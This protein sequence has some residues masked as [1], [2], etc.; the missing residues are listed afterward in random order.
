MDFKED[1]FL[2]IPGN[3]TDPG[4]KQVF[5][6]IVA[7]N[8]TLKEYMQT[9][10][11]KTFTLDYLKTYTLEIREIKK[12][13]DLYFICS[14]NSIYYSY[15]ES[16]RL[17]LFN[18]IENPINDFIFPTSK[19]EPKIKIK[20]KYINI[21]DFKGKYLYKNN[22]KNKFE[23]RKI[24]TDYISKNSIEL[25]V[26]YQIHTIKELLTISFIEI[27]KNN[28]TINKCQNCGKYF[29]P[30]S[31]SDEKYCNNPSPQNP[32]KTCKEY[33]AKKKYRDEIK[34]HPIKYEHNKTSQ[35]YRMRINRTKNNQEKEKYEKKFN[36]Y[37]EN[38]EKKKKQYNSGKLKEND[39]V[40]WIIKQKE[41]VKNGS[42]RTNK[43]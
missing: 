33:G 18:V 12:L 22:T 8:S 26:T 13:I 39:F 4:I 38:F 29:I 17:F 35:F 24:L 1:V 2:K 41:G 25:F 42:S 7:T 15:E 20:N 32:D 36:A 19:V 31:R 40:E 6:D 27:L 28:L 43:K 23:R 3:I 16:K 21:W 5:D 14:S 9:Q 11:I 10:T 30:E 37:K 34:S